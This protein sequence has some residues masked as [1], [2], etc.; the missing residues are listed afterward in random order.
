MQHSDVKVALEFLLLCIGMTMVCT[1]LCNITDFIACKKKRAAVTVSSPKM[2][3]AGKPPTC[4][5]ALRRYAANE[6]DKNAALIPR[7]VLLVKDL[8]TENAG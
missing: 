6:L 4:I 7:L 8:I 3:F 5:N 1:C 2:T